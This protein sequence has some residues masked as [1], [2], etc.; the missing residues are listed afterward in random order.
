MAEYF[1][2]P[3]ISCPFLIVIAIKYLNAYF[4]VSPVLNLYASWKQTYPCALG[5]LSLH[6]NSKNP[7]L[8]IL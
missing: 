6:V 8:L 4:E 5:S 7:G 2:H 3:F 1:A